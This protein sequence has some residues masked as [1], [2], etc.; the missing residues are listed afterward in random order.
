M[1]AEENMALARRFLEARVVKRDLDAVDEM[2][3]PDFVNHNK[4]VPGQEPDRENYLR[5]IAAFH[6]A[7]SPGRLIIEDQV[8]GEDKVVTR[9]VV[10]SLHDRGELMGVAPSGRD[11]TNRVIIIHRIVEGK[12]AEEWGMGTIGATLRKQRLEREIRERE[13]VEQE[14][15]V[16]RSIQQASLPKEVPTLE[17]WQINP[18]YQPAREVGGDFYEYF[19]LDDGRVGFAVGDATGKG[20]PAAFVMSATCA[21]LGGVATASGS[22][23]GEVLARVNEALLTRIP[24]N[25]FVTCFYCTL[26][27]ES[28]HLLYANAGHDLPYLCRGDDAEE[29]RARGMPLGLMPGMSYEEKDTVLDA[30]EA[31]LFYSDGLVEAHD[32]K[33]EMFGFPRLQ[34]LVAQHGKEHSLV[35]SLLEE[36]YSFVGEGWE[37]EDDITL[38]TLRCSAPLS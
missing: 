23:P 33:G 16:A 18:Y 13:R 29:L 5:G 32:P 24:P 20:V 3:A 38:L 4:S 9:F 26:D 35:D 34:A 19:V 25:M 37:Q 8:A 15:R 12:I 10:H 28:G 6:A 30:G 31:A 7:L 14:M 11:L 2:L 1:S 17:G 27:P 21:L 22:S 36:L